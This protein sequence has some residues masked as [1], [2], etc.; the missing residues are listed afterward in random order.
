MS[1]DSH[2]VTYAETW[3]RMYSVESLILDPGQYLL[4]QRGEDIYL[5]G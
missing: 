2:S 1:D 4:T 3:E 5:E